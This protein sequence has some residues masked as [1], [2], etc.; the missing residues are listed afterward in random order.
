MA[1]LRK[2]VDKLCNSTASLLD[3]H[4]VL[5]VLPTDSEEFDFPSLCTC[6]QNGTRATSNSV[7][8]LSLAEHHQ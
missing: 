4:D 2:A 7:G 3:G 5:A 1:L 8:A 6:G